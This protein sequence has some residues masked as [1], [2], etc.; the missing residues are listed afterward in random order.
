MNYPKPITQYEETSD[1]DNRVCPY[2][3]HS[4]HIECQD[5]NEEERVDECEECGKKFHVS[6]V[7][8][9]THHARPDCE[10]NGEEHIF[11]N[12]I[13]SIYFF[14]KKC[15]VL[16]V[17]MSQ[18]PTLHPGTIAVAEALGIPLDE[19]QPTNKSPF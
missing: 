7:Y 13:S 8:S 14:C 19:L 17:D 6:E 12:A 10:L 1:D 2:C 15:D 11:V 3:Q 4:H 9:V 18:K 16:K 5:Y